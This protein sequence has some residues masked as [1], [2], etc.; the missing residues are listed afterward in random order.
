MKLNSNEILVSV[1]IGYNNKLIVPATME[2]AQALNRA[3]ITEDRWLS[4]EKTTREFLAPNNVSI[5]ILGNKHELPT[6]T[7]EQYVQAVKE[8]EES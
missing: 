8:E 1:S 2:V 4:E 3:V 5:A 7:Y 6:I